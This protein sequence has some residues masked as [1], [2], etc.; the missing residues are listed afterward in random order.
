[1]SKGKWK[2]IP[3]EKECVFCHSKYLGY[4]SSKYCSPRCRKDAYNKRLKELNPRYCIVCDK[5]L[6]DNKHFK[7]CSEE[8]KMKAQEMQTVRYYKKDKKE[9]SSLSE[10]AKKATEEGLTYGQYCI[11]H[12]L[13]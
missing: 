8:C 2:E 7:Y 5:L 13:Y 9:T 12:G 11:K 10:I 4:R 3:K 6:T 1:M